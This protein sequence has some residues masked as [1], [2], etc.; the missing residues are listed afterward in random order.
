VT[1]EIVYR[2]WRVTGNVGSD[3][4]EI[5]VGDTGRIIFGTCTCGFF[6][7]NLMSKGPCEH[8]LAV[9]KASG[10]TRKDLPTSTPA[11][12]VPKPPLKSDTEEEDGGD[13]EEGFDES[14][15]DENTESR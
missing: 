4:A 3:K 1:R 10:D 14:E 9:F 11:A 5:V 12:V 8:M 7:D 13:S 15:S 6:Q 2:D